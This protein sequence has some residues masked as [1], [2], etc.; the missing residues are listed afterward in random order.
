VK[1]PS[2]IK[3][4]INR[5]NSSLEEGV[6]SEESYV[7]LLMEGFIGSGADDHHPDMQTDVCW[8]YPRERRNGSGRE[9]KGEFSQNILQQSA[10]DFGRQPW[11][12]ER[13]RDQRTSHGGHC[14][15]SGGAV[16]EKIEI[17]GE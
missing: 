4:G 7:V 12:P 17:F 2:L 11:F 5:G 15:C 6:R 1:N 14:G 13:R 3:W 8:F 9:R 16:R 10:K